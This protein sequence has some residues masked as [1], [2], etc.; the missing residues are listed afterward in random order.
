MATI[1]NL[2]SKTATVLHC[3][4]FFQ[5]QELFSQ[6]E[7]QLKKF[8]SLVWQIFLTTNMWLRSSLR[9]SN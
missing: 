8:A 9:S 7:L 3:F 1:F 6:A 4:Q 2:L 5:I